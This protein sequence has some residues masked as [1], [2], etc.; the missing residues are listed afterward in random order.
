MSLLRYMFGYSNSSS[1]ND[2]DASEHKVI[3][4]NANPKFFTILVAGCYACL[5]DYFGFTDEQHV[6]R[7]L[8]PILTI[9]PN[10]YFR[11][12][13][14]NIFDKYKFVFVDCDNIVVY[15]EYKQFTVNL[16]YSHSKYSLSIQKDIID[17]TCQLIRNSYHGTNDNCCADVATAKKYGW[18]TYFKGF[19]FKICNPQFIR[20]DS[21]DMHIMDD[22]ISLFNDTNYYRNSKH[23]DS[24]H[25]D[26]EDH[27]WVT[28][29]EPVT[30]I[31]LN[32]HITFHGM[33]TVGTI[34]LVLAGSYNGNNKFMIRD[35]NNYK[36]TIDNISH[37]VD[38]RNGVVHGEYKLIS[39]SGYS[40]KNYQHGVQSGLGYHYHNNMT[41]HGMV[42]ELSYHCSDYSV[43]LCLNP[44]YQIIVNMHDK[45]NDQYHRMELVIDDMP[46][47]CC[48]H[49]HDG[50]NNSVINNNNNE[51]N[52]ESNNNDNRLSIVW[53]Q[54]HNTSNFNID[55]VDNTHG[56]DIINDNTS[57]NVVI[58]RI[59]VDSCAANFIVPNIWTTGLL[60]GIG[61]TLWWWYWWCM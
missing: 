49:T 36:L 37:F 21:D 15:N 52:N 13:Y 41:G 33:N 44:R 48:Y 14:C 9:T 24:K 57:N 29:D 59:V 47:V 38:Y 54:D 8:N 20:G 10:P 3:Y 56:N 22:I 4:N 30:T 28:V 34:P 46:K 1:S 31:N 12:D 17:Q 16:N 58:K 50:N 6:L 40:L 32:S 53:S 11:G 7:Y 51:S 39:N 43:I 19:N 42:N 35:G 2:D 60:G 25:C 55:I 18:Y 61:W 5:V 27:D 45:H 26:R 23:C